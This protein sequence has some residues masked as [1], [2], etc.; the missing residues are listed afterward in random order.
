MAVV[1]VHPSPR[2]ERRAFCAAVSS[3][4]EEPLA[5][6]ASRIDHWLLV[7]Y[8]GA[9]TR[10]VLGESLLSPELKEH[11]RGQLASLGRARLLFVKQPERRAQTGR[12]VFF[13]TSKPGQERFLAL[14]VEHQNDLIGF[15]FVTAL[16]A[17]GGPASPVEGPLFVVC[18]H[19]KRDRCCAKFGRPLYDS[20][21]HDAEPGRVWQSTHVGGDRFAGNVV[22]LP[23]GLYYGRVDP[24]DT[25]PLVATQAAGRID[26]DR[27]RGRSAWS[28]PVQAAERALRESEG[29]LGIDDLA[30]LGSSAQGDGAWRVRFRTRDEAV[31]EADVE[32]V[33]A[34]E[35]AY[36]TCDA[37]EPRRARRHV[38]TAHRVLSR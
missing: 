3:A 2:A 12:Q 6:T 35:P 14:E 8:R 34:D 38:V 30:F 15:D 37:A 10:D 31:H 20:L 4:S 26:L 17:G 5:A 28:F 21:R 23:Y 27:Y 36:L 13:G 9:W 25:G 1:S 32:T 7:E 24:V 18:T 29:L 22:V 19:G 33:V 16:G 11:L